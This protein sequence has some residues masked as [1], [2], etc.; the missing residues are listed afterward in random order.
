MRCAWPV[1][2]AQGARILEPLALSRPADD[3]DRRH[4]RHACGYGCVRCGA[5]IYQ[6]RTVSGSADVDDIV[7]LCP[8][9]AHALAGRPGAEQ[10]L[11]IMRQRPVARQSQFDRR[12]LPYA[13]EMPDLVVVPGVTMR[14]TPMP[15][16]FGGVPVLRL[17]APEVPGGAVEIGITLA[18]A[19]EAPRPVVVANEW[20]PQGG[21]GD[22]TFERPGN[23]YV[24]TSRDRSAQLILAAVTPGLLALELLRTFDGCRMLESG[25]NGTRIDG[26]ACPTPAVKSQIVGMAV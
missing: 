12:K 10:A 2:F 7:L 24:I 6:Y 20:L 23:R 1:G 19:G 13:L 25:H 5:T 26:V 9:C 11:R 14:K 8:P 21:E 22:W 15:I 16:L 18:M 4:V 3:K 17:D